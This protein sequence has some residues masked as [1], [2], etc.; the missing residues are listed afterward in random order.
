MQQLCSPVR[1]VNICQWA[2]HELQAVCAQ[3]LGSVELLQ[4]HRSRDIFPRSVCWCPCCLSLRGCLLV[5]NKDKLSQEL[6]SLCGYSDPGRWKHLPVTEWLLWTLEYREGKGEVRWKV[7]PHK[8]ENST[9]PS[10]KSFAKNKSDQEG[11]CPGWRGTIS[12]G[13]LNSKGQNQEEKSWN[14]DHF[15]SG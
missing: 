6:F 3:D 15:R 8:Q 14:Q 12:Q 9:F 5:G 1:E 11:T 13:S 7:C 10:A 2:P 4:T